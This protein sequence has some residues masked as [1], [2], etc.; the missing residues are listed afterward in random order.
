MFSC[1]YFGK[2][3]RNHFRLRNLLEVNTEYLQALFNNELD[4][5]LS[6]ETV[7]ASQGYGPLVPCN[8]TA[9]AREQK[10][11]CRMSVKTFVYFSHKYYSNV[12]S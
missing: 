2:G 7:A 5:I 9:A 4:R 11:L 12:A 3:H 8:I 1:E 10:E 6:F